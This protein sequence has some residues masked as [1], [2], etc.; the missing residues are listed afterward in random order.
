MVG[1]IATVVHGFGLNSEKFDHPLVPIGTI[2][3]CGPSADDADKMELED[4][5][6]DEEIVEVEGLIGLRAWGLEVG[7]I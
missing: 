2:W 1:Y 7:W 5:H 6:Q 3:L 4:N